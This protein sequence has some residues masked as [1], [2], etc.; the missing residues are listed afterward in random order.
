M[1]APTS[2][3]STSNAELTQADLM[4][5]GL[6]QASATDP[7]AKPILI[8]KSLTDMESMM[9]QLGEPAF[10][11]RQLHSWVYVHAA[12]D[13][14]DMTSLGK[15]LRTQLKEK[16]QVG[17]LKLADKQVSRD[18]TIKYLFELS[19]GQLIESVMMP[20]QHRD[21]TSICLSTQVGCAVNCGFCATGKLGL[22][23][24]LTA[25]EMVEQLLFVTRDSGKDI[26]NLVFMGQGEP[27]HNYDEF[28]KA[29]HLIN[30]SAELGMRH[31]TVST[32]GLVPQILKLADE[33]L[34]MTL[35]V[36]L[37]APDDET[38][39]RFMPINQRYPI[40]ELMKALYVYY[41]KTRRRITVEYILLAGLNDTEQ[42]AKAL[43][44]LLKDLHC[45]INLIP[46]NP[47]GAEYGFKRPQR[48]DSVRFKRTL[49]ANTRHKVTIRLE[50][51][52]DIDAACG[53]LANKHQ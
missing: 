42:H 9:K 22:K 31:M 32:A 33:G 15:G 26:K 52:A 24:N 2:P 50:R 51:G 27:L 38:R 11:G 45:N 39:N 7:P 5:A 25:A 53:Q 29:L 21:S 43:G 3:S 35:A 6:A 30:Q 18:G 48:V 46:Y 47:I 10:R 8:G 36:S 40:K 17:Q 13:F 19:D 28:I 20:F 49:E 4:Q 41:E 44:K 1:P 14:D 23:R 37:H 34:Q 12:N 16:Y